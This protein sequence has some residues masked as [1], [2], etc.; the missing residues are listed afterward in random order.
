MKSRKISFGAI[1][2][3]GIKKCPDEKSMFWHD[4]HREKPIAMKR[5]FAGGSLMV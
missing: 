5:H 3:N 2:R 4:N 1:R